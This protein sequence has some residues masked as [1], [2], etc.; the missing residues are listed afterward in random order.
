MSWEDRAQANLLAAVNETY[1][2][3][4]AQQRKAKV[5]KVVKTAQEK[6]I[7]KKNFPKLH[8]EVFKSS[9]APAARQVSIPSSKLA[10][11]HR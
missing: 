6:V 3:L 11:K 2:A 7:F 1:N 8:K 9:S 5:R 10:A 4:P